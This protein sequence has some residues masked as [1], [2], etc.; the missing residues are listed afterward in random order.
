MVSTDAGGLSAEK[1]VVA[2]VTNVNEAPAITSGTT[3]SVAENAPVSTVIYTV[4]SEDVDDND[5][6]TYSLKAGEDDSA[7]LNIDAVTGVV[8]LKDSANFEIKDSYSFTVVS[9]DAGGLSAE[10]AIVATVTNVNEAPAITSGTTGSVAENAPVSTVIYTVTSEDVDDNDTAT[11]SLKAG[12]DDSALLNIDAVTGVVTL[13]DSANFEIKDSYSFTVVSTDAGGLSAEKVVVATVTNVNEAPTGS[14]TA[15][16]AAGIEDTTYTIQ[17]SDLL[18]GFSDVDNALT[19]VNLV[20]TDGALTDNLNGTW[21]FLPHTNS[22]GN[23]ALAYGVTDGTTTIAATQSFNV[24]LVNDT[25]VLNIPAQIDYIDTAVTDN[26]ATASGTLVA[27]DV[28][29]SSLTYNIV[30][31]TDNGDTV[32]KDS[33]Y[34]VLTVTKATGDYTFVANDDAIN[35]LVSTAGQSFTVTA[36]DGLLIDSQSLIINIAQQGSTESMGNDIL[37]GTSDNDIFHGLTGNDSINGLLG[38]DTMIGGLGN[39]KYVVDN[40]GDKVVESSKLATEIDSVSSSIDY[41]LPANVE[42]LTLTNRAVNGSGNQLNNTL[43][44]DAGANKLSGGAGIDTLI[45]NAGADILNGGAGKDILTGGTGKDIF[46][47]TSL[48][49][50]TITDFVVVHDTIQ[51]ENSVF[52]H[53]TTTGMLNAASL[54]IGAAATDANDYVIY[55]SNT[56]ALLYDADGNGAHAPTQI[57]LLGTHLALT[58]ADF[59]II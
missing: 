26:F 4:T 2:T 9:T 12:E 56:G 37:M 22:T 19:V 45:G 33:Q 25:P 43:T 46:Q 8:T 39:D 18:Q 21:S 23:V 48:S 54:K 51:L 5:T 35:A 27:D 3:G 49:K 59:I 47:L 13:K 11:Y 38:A 34:G 55:N 15:V 32:S 50:D 29:N 41:T 40:I 30:D 53:L 57:A 28:D 42:N 36:S 44:G 10:K 58:N 17:A 6:A 16:L 31:G 14:A 7:L 1:A 20:A 52:T 24:A